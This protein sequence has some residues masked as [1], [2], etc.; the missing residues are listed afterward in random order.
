MGLMNFIEAKKIFIEEI[1]KLERKE[2]LQ[3][4]SEIVMRGLMV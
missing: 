2:L 4:Y 1:M 3:Q